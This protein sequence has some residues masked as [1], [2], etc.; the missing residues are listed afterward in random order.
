VQESVD[1]SKMDDPDSPELS[2][3]EDGSETSENIE[4]EEDDDYKLR[5]LA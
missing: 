1:K 3:F 4:E 2:K 5:M